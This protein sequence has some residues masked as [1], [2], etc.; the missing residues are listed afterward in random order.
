MLG[1]I[2]RLFGRLG[3]DVV[4]GL[5]NFW[6]GGP[7]LKKALR[8][9]A[10]EDIPDTIH[11][12]K[13]HRGKAAQQITKKMDDAYDEVVKDLRQRTQNIKDAESELG[14][15]SRSRNKIKRDLDNAQ[16]DAEYYRAKASRLGDGPDADAATE[17]Y[18][19]NQRRVDS[20]EDDLLREAEDVRMYREKLEQQMTEKKELEN[21]FSALE[22][23]PQSAL[24][25][26]KYNPEI[27]S[28]F[29]VLGAYARKAED[30]IGHKSQILNSASRNINND[31]KFGKEYL[32]DIH[33]Y[34]G[35]GGRTGDYADN[36]M[37]N[38][39]NLTK[40]EEMM[41]NRRFSKYLNI[42]EGSKAAREALR[43]LGRK[44]LIGKLGVPLT[45]VATIAGPMAVMSWLDDNAP[46]VAAESGHVSSYLK[47]F[48]SSDLGEQIRAQTLNA[49]EATQDAMHDVEDN[50]HSDPTAAVSTSINTLINSKAII[51]KNLGRWQL[52]VMSSNDKEAATRAGQELQA[53]SH[54]LGK[55]VAGLEHLTGEHLKRSQT[56]RDTGLAGDVRRKPTRFDRNHVKS[57]QTYLSR[58]FP[59]VAPTGILDRPTIQALRKLEREFDE[60]G[61]TGRFSSIRLL[62]RPKENHLIELQDLIN[63]EKVLHRGG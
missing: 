17:N 23:S 46:E 11:K 60:L 54:Q 53:Y 38:P 30:A 14:R 57:I 12:A 31:Y 39:Q 21:L 25:Q 13:L 20:L 5:K 55:R 19:R 36:W 24:S 28:K 4:K 43:G 16:R 56:P 52:V 7:D 9:D 26:I 51:D 45:S 40:L 34:L 15:V 50:M 29:P 3:D 22:D 58:K 2:G 18:Y 37:A 41:R 42:D 44:E 33:P 47:G 63:L 49:V 10:V 27:R 8:L 1:G 48:K 62:V 61:N 35:K 32:R 6:R 59:E